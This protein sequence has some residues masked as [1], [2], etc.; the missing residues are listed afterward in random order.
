MER[1]VKVRPEKEAVVQE[2]KDK[3][4][5]A[6]GVVLTEY[7]GL[8]VQQLSDLR[9]RLRAQSIDYHVLKNTLVR[10]A[11]NEIDLNELEPYLVGPMAIAFG[12]DD[13]LAPVKVLSEFARG[14]KNFV[15]KAGL[16]EGRVFDAKALQSIAL[17]P[18]KEVLLA[19]VVGGLQSPISG[20]VYV[21]NGP[22][23]KLAM[24]LGQI[25]KEKEAQ[26]AA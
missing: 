7:R 17:L 4:G 26:G 16:V 20:L 3:L 10:I 22:V 11:A 15:L 13:P 21:L 14:V 24:A 12:Y 25:A 1:E 18:P 23:Q 5:R 2:V 8:N 9:R 6:K 19:K